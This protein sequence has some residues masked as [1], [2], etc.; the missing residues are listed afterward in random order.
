MQER[1]LVTDVARINELWK[2]YEAAVNADDFGLWRLKHEVFFQLG[3]Q[4]RDSA[5]RHPE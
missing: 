5:E 2:A 3:H 1:S 4:A